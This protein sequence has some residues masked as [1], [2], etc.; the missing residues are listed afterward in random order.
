MHQVKIKM[1][2]AL[3]L[4]QLFLVLV[5]LVSFSSGTLA[6]P[7]A[8]LSN[9]NQP[10]LGAY[11]PLSS[12]TY[13]A[14]PFVTDNRFTQL[15]GAEINAVTLSSPGNMFV[16]I[17]D[18]D[19]AGRPGNVVAT[20]NGP[21]EP[22]GLTQYTGTVNLQPDTS[23]F[24]VIGVANG[25]SSAGTAVFTTDR[26]QADSQPPPIY[27]IGTDFNGDGA[28]DFVNKCTGSVSGSATISWVCGGVSATRFFPEFRIL[29]EIPAPIVPPAPPSLIS[30]P[31]FLDFGTITQGTTSAPLNATIENNGGVDQVFGSLSLASGAPFVISSDACS[32]ATL[33]PGAS[34]V[35]GV[36]FAATGGGQFSDTVIIPLSTDP[37]S[38]YGL[39]LVG[40]GDNPPDQSL[41]TTPA[42]LDFGV[43]D[44]GATTSVQSIRVE[45]NGNVDQV[46]G[47]LS[48]L[49]PFAIA[50][51]NCSGM[52]LTSAATC[53]VDITFSPVVAGLASGELQIPATG[54]VKSPYGV[55]LSGEG[56]TLAP[57]Y[58]LTSTPLFLDFGL[59]PDG[60]TSAAQTAVIENDGNVTQV[61]GAVSV[62]TGFALASDDCSG[63]TLAPGSTCSIDVTFSPVHGGV[64]SG[65]AIIPATSDPRSPYGLV[66]TGESD[67]PGIALPPSISTEPKAVPLR[68]TLLTALG[69][70]LLVAFRHRKM[71]R[72]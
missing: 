29:A 32:G 52:T 69:L 72:D 44:L 50:T 40:E 61:L 10:S 43:I 51:D 17:W 6:L 13:L 12:R 30:N 7:T 8:V 3:S 47:A 14:V 60:S 58:S 38:P 31:L 21:P 63:S 56:S 19:Y 16:Q 5:F 62:G 71:S 42:G 53:T 57:S 33:A 41:T 11:D 65:T 28:I 9:F 22:A 20:L 64:T 70:I 1:R 24:L 66:L 54:D 49:G 23:Y 68:F 18:I 26:N 36:T 15:D 25:A 45:N 2:H 59:V 67:Q 39:Q 35:I 48:V 37:S 55:P 46:L 4:P 34:C 27:R